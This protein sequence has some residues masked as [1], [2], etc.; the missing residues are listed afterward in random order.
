MSYF[1]SLSFSKEAE[2]EMKSIGIYHKSKTDL[3]MDEYNVNMTQNEIIKKEMK[4]LRRTINKGRTR[5]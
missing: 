5:K 2:E 3:L 4:S 1:E